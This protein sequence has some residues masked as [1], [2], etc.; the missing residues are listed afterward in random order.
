M[1]MDVING[2]DKKMDTNDFLGGCIIKGHNGNC[3]EIGPQ[4]VENELFTRKEQQVFYQ[5][6]GILSCI[7]KA[8]HLFLP[9]KVQAHKNHLFT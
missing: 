3:D 6:K 7:G 9:L 4:Y 2:C 1:M 8:S 5:V